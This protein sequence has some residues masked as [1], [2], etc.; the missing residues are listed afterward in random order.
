MALLVYLQGK[1]GY[2]GGNAAEGKPPRQCSE[3]KRIYYAQWA[4]ETTL[5][6]RL[7]TLMPRYLALILADQQVDETLQYPTV[8]QLRKTAEELNQMY[9]IV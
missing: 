7:R 4:M 2:T 9:H 3:E 6:G 8:E 1:Q 5:R